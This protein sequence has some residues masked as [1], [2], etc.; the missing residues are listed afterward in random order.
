MGPTGPN[1]KKS[2]SEIHSTPCYLDSQNTLCHYAMVISECQKDDSRRMGQEPQAF[3][4]S[5]DLLGWILF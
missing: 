2:G 4:F 5:D 1:T 3:K